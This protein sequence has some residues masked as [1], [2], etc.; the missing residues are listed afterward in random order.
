M[1]NKEINLR[2]NNETF[3]KYKFQQVRYITIYH[4]QDVYKHTM[5]SD[6]FSLNFGRKYYLMANSIFM[7]IRSK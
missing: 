5:T 6:A 3:I 7:A 1:G 2:F 4:A